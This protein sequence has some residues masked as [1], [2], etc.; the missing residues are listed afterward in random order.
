MAAH[1][2][3]AA[4]GG[5]D[6]KSLGRSSSR[7]GYVPYSVRFPDPEYGIRGLCL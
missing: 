5:E 2:T 6:T 1:E 4:A 7:N 3:N